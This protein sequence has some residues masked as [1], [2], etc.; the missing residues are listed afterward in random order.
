M[1]GIGNLISTSDFTVL[2]ILHEKLSQLSL[3]ADPLGFIIQ[4]V[5]VSPY[6]TY[7]MK[8][9]TAPFICLLMEFIHLLVMRT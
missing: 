7:E 2:L 6:E 3:S 1:F 9:L 8:L 4:Q 5:N